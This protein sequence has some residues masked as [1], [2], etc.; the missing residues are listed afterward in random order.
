MKGGEREL[1]RLKKM[2]RKDN[3]RI[4]NEAIGMLKSEVITVLDGYLNV[5]DESVEL[6]FFTEEGGKIVFTLTGKAVGVRT[7][8][9][10]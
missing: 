1:D 6:A 7:I 8:R 9:S 5:E 4:P 3:F 2:I 10:L